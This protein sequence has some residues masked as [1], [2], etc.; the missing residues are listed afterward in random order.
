MLGLT[1]ALPGP[2]AAQGSWS[3]KTEFTFDGAVQVPNATL[4]AGTYV[5]K[6]ADTANDRAVAEIWNEDETERISTAIVIPT[7]RP[8]PVDEVNITFASTPSG[9]PPAVIAWFYPGDSA[10]HEFVYPEEQARRI[11]RTT[12]TLVLSA[13]ID[14]DDPEGWEITT[15]TRFDEEGN[16]QPWTPGQREQARQSRTGRGGGP[17]EQ[18]QATSSPTDRQRGDEQQARTGDEKVGMTGDRDPATTA[19]P[20]P[21]A[22]DERNAMTDDD[23]RHRPPNVRA[24]PGDAAEGSGQVQLHG[25]EGEDLAE[26]HL[27]HA[28]RLADEILQSQQTNTVE[29]SKIEQLRDHVDQAFKALDGG[30]S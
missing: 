13:D 16:P 8:E 22:T 18:R 19:A 21:G 12:K 25:L 1:V 5:F 7:V 28:R 14:P 6:L 15:F 24:E 11:A 27:E 4:D 30:S 17:G 3:E 26:H 10:G 9:D 29:R 23:Y 2:A 20:Q